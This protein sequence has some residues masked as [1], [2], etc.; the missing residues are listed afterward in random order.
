[1]KDLFY[2]LY[3]L[4]WW[5]YVVVVL[6]LTHITIAAVT[7][8]LHRA[9]A[10]RALKVH[11]IVSHFFRAWLWL[12][13]GMETKAWAAI[14]RKHHAKCETE[15]DPH[16]PQV[17]GLP[18]VLWK[19]AELYR[20]EAHNLETLERYGHG[21]PDDWLERNLYTPYSARGIILMLIIDLV[22]F[23]V[24]GLT[25][26]AIQMAWIPFF[27]AGV[28]NGIAHF[29]GYRNFECMDAAHNIIPWGILIGGEE[30]HN[31]HHTYPT[32]AKLSV[33]WWEFDIGW[34]YIRIL[35]MLGLAEVK[36]QVPQ[37][38][39]IPGKM[40]IDAETL[41]ALIVNRVDVM[42]RFS[43]AV[44]SPVFKAEVQ[45]AAPEDKRLWRLGSSVSVL[46]RSER[47]V[48]DS[49]RQ[50]IKTLLEKSPS[51]NHAYSFGKRLQ[52]IWDRTTATQKELLDALHEWCTHAETSGIRGL[53]E[54]A[55]FLKGY[56][57]TV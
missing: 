5:G 45:K 57:A 14:H 20:S 29:W 26:W 33:H 50:R 9:Q 15:E 43:K 39:S 1:M 49:L 54:F 34:L 36:R 13:T 18:K 30:L 48:N 38:K 31:N 22:L 47:L 17:L 8:Y 21:T 51:L 4:P 40:A 12:T 41:R 27:A 24:P 10:H 19:G 52:A 11:P 16:S 23:G 25:I 56:T 3:E 7:I 42:T 46:V 53:P 35:S 6:S 32:S 2:G 37:V 55:Q 44:I 28:V